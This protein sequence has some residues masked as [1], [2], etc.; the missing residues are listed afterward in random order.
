MLPSTYDWAIAADT[1]PLVVAIHGWAQQPLLAVGS[2]GSLTTA[3]FA[4]YLHETHAGGMAKAV[5]PLEIVSHSRT[6]RDTVVMFVSAGGRNTDIVGALRHVIAREPKRLLVLCGN[7]TSPM[8]NLARAY[9]FTDLVTFDLPSANDGFL[10][11]NSLI[12]FSTLLSR[13]YAVAFGQADDLGRHLGG[14]VH[15]GQTGEQFHA[16]LDQICRQLWKRESLLLLHGVPTRSA[17][18]DLESKF[19]EAALGPVQVADYRNF[20]H[21][22]HHWLAKRGQSTA[23]LAIASDE[24]RQL[25][26]ETLSLLPRDIPIAKVYVPQ[27]GATASIASQ[28]A[29]LHIV[30]LAG[31]S[32]GIDPG[33]PGVPSFGSRIY[34]LRGLRRLTNHE[35]LVNQSEAVAIERKAGLGLESL[36]RSDEMPFWRDAYRAFVEGLQRT[37]FDAIVF[38]YD[39]TLCDTQDRYRGLADEVAGQ[40]ERL[41][42][43]GTL[44]GIATGRGKSIKRVLRDKIAP[45]MWPKVIVGY[46]NGADIGLLSED[47]HPDSGQDP[48]PDLAPI[49]AAIKSDV[50]LSRLADAEHRRTQISVQVR[51]SVPVALVWDIVQ[52]I[53]HGTARDA[54]TVLRSSHSV[55]ILAPHV[56]KCLLVE[57]VG[58]MTGRGEQARTLCIGDKGR[59]PGNDFDL[60]SLPFS[61]SVDEVSPDANT[62]WNLAPPGYRGTQA[63]MSYLR[64]V[65]FNRRLS[66]LSIR[67]PGGPGVD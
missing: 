21:G 51:P 22:R 39:G 18:L 8:S 63:T 66:C 23:V 37:Y 25:A 58:T 34:R 12:A 1:N 67:V 45:A 59:W 47:S 46:Y 38:D 17:A 5:T 11:T 64:W 36:I 32:R 24:D 14:L 65:R 62:C 19:S 28:V 60:L 13:A 26:D 48:C 52:Q 2:G 54:V 42:R 61:L 35:P 6:L 40:V 29:V 16:E 4:A 44:I 49:S 43:A 31:E 33:R 15:P 9:R 53:I 27:R 55:D 7:S 56:S 30:G 20:A 41:L 57:R 10:A 3:N 50:R